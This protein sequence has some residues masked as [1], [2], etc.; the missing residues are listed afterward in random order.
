MGNPD[1]HRETRWTA[2]DPGQPEQRTKGNRQEGRGRH[3]TGRLWEPTVSQR[4]KIK[5]LWPKQLWSLE[6]FSSLLGP[7]LPLTPK[8]EHD[9]S[10][11]E[12]G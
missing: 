3:R 9:Y 4:D 10:R 7:V 5:R 11:R 12:L 1:R 8:K 6:A 2:S